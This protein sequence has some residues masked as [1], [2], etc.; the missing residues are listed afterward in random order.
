[1]TASVMTPAEQLPVPVLKYPH[2]RV[3]FRPSAYDPTRLKTLSD[4]LG[5]LQKTR[6]QLRGWAFPPVPSA[7]SLGYGDTWIAGWSDFMEH[8][9][10]WRF[11]Q[12]TQFLYLGSV[13]EV[14]ETQWAV[15]LRDIM[16]MWAGLRKVDIDA[17]PGFLSLTN[18]IYNITEY[19]EFAAR[20]AQAQI[21]TDPVTIAISIK[22]VAGFMLAADENRRWNSDYVTHQPELSYVK[23]FAPGDLISSAADHAL[24]CTLWLF[25]RFG[26]LKPNVD[27]IRTDQQKLLTG[28]F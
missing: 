2:W 20:L 17:V 3:N 23:T 4:C 6:V 21:Y 18:S 7:P 9:E 22:G 24:D 26:W 1:M 19:F 25:E 15:K 13:Q 8:L 27:A 16:R 5:V 12:S 28:Q 11:Y 14:T 10:Y